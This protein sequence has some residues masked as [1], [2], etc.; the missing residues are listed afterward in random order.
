MVAA[1]RRARQTGSPLV[2]TPFAHLGERENDRVALNSTMNHQLRMMREAARL[3]ALTRVEAEGLARYHMWPDRLH[4]IGSAADAPPADFRDSSY[5]A[6]DHCEARGVYGLYIGR[7]SYDKGALHAADAIR[8]LRRRGRDVALLLIGSVTPEF[9]RYRQ[10]LSPTERA[11]IRPL[12][13][14]SDRDKHAVLSRARFLMLPSRSD[15]FGIVLLE[16]WSHSVPVIAAR[17]GGIPGVVDDGANGL[18]VPFADVDGLAAAAE[19]IVGDEP[20][21]QRL[22]RQGN[23]KLRANYSWDVV[24]ER[25]QSHYRQIM[26]DHKKSAKSA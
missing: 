4:V 23:E 1:Y 3:L 16:A 6:D 15:S 11:A 19:R 24:V 8:A 13:V 12:G 20:F 5:F 14:L 25:V 7:L 2:V 26:L 18:L 17:A 21:A 9:K 22:G 10:R